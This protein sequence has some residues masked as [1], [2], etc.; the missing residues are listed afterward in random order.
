[1]IDMFPSREELQLLRSDR[2]CRKEYFLR[3]AAWFVRS[4]GM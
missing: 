1:M 3:I 2:T 4:M